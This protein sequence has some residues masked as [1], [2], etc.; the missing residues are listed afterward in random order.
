[1][2]TLLRE[3]NP[4]DAATTVGNAASNPQK[5]PV[6]E[7]RDDRIRVLQVN[8]RH[9][10]GGS[11]RLAATIGMSLDPD[12]FE[13][14]FAAM[15]GDGEV[16]QMLR[17]LGYSTNVFGRREGFD[18]SA[19]WRVWKYLSKT[20][21]DI[22]QT[23]HVGSLVYCAP[24]ARLLG[25]KVV[26]TE[27]D[28]H[29]FQRLPNELRW[30]RRL[31]GL[32]HCYVAI[33]P[34]I[35]DFLHDQGIS[36][37]RIH[38][39]RN[40]I[41]LTKFH[42]PK[43]R[44]PA[45]PGSNYVIG[46]IARMAA[47][48]RPDILID[49]LAILARED[50]A[51]RGRFIGS[52]DL[53]PLIQARA[54][55][56][57]VADRVEFLGARDD[58][59]EQ[60]RELDCYVLCSEHEGLPI[61]L[62]EAMATELPCI[63]SAVG[64]IPDLLSDEIHGLLLKGPDAQDLADKIRRLRAR[65]DEARKMGQK[66]GVLARDSFDLANTIEQY[67][68]LFE[69][70][71]ADD[72]PPLRSRRLLRPIKRAAFRALAGM[73][74]DRWALPQSADTLL[75][76]GYHGVAPDQSA[77]QKSWLLLP[78]AEF[79]Q[80]ILY[81]K[82]RYQVVP[83]SEAARKLAEGVPFE[84]PTACVTFDDGYKNNAT[85]AAPILM[86]HSIPATIYLATGLIGSKEILWMP[87]LER[88]MASSSRPRLRLTDFGLG[89]FPL[90]GL[91]ME[92]FV[93]LVGVLYR[94]PRHRRGKILSAAV[95][96]LDANLDADLSAFE[97]MS[98]DDVAALESTGFFEFGGH[99][100]SHQILRPLSEGEIERE[101]GQSIQDV[102]EHSQ[103]PQTTFAYPNGTIEDFDDRAKEC[104]RRHGILAAVSTIEG[105]NSSRSDRFA[106]RRVV[107]GSQMPI[108]EFRLRACGLV[109]WGR[110]RMRRT[111]R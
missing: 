98:W 38:V 71:V 101:I 110:D 34:T 41:D 19:V 70:V 67:Q 11:E 55:T 5:A 49:A 16:G 111:E 85:V 46:W 9:T 80:Q 63:V 57:G 92:S 62:V 75:V 99:T 30:L 58:V 69:S 53:L 108:G 94:M 100:V 104:L 105:V 52:G 13:S 64:G 106:L 6:V 2:L 36:R 48:K 17:E 76:V 15:K 51:I 35:G 89:V 90:G 14:L 39:I 96:R 61:S 12:R 18:P 27:H 93:Q 22:V 43:R 88:A 95:Q 42:P 102:A 10:F 23:H 21:I 87:R 66:G 72:P 91:W 79:E 56:A 54:E 37:D 25:R 26:H 7:V 82:D 59:A 40:G 65:P 33:D 29:T 50:P 44:P 97:M 47:P 4:C 24:P 77:R 81:L 31:S 3:H 45:N 60:L 74:V 83:F 28:I 20:P 109:S 107:V 73:R 68:E 1:M 32:P 84:T 103:R 78:Q 86:R 8:H